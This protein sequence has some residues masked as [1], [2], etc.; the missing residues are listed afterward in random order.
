MGVEKSFRTTYVGR[1][2]DDCFDEFIMVKFDMRCQLDTV[3]TVSLP[4][5][6]NAEVLTDAE[7]E[8]LRERFRSAMHDVVEDEKEHGLL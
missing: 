4:T 8:Q 2:L 1:I 7:G 3:N 5:E 6:L